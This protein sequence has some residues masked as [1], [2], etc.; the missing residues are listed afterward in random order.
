M[1]ERKRRTILLP[2]GE[3]GA[4]PVKRR[5]D[6]DSVQCKQD[7]EQDE[8]PHGTYGVVKLVPEQQRAIKTQRELQSED[9]GAVLSV[10]VREIGVLS[11]FNVHPHPNIVR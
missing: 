2:D 4:I 3:F 7:K 1:G 5:A 8:D 11:G 10:N 9:C 6:N